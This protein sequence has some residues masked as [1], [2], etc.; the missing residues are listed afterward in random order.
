MANALRFVYAAYS[1]LCNCLIAFLSLPDPPKKPTIS[2]TLPWS[3]IGGTFSTSGMTNWAVPCAAYFSSNSSR[4]LKY[5][6]P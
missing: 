2:S 1:S 4:M 6:L 5:S 3:E